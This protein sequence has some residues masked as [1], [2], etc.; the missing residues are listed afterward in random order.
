[1]EVEP[2][3]VRRRELLCEHDRRRAVAAPHVGDGTAGHQRV[4]DTVERVDPVR[5]LGAV[6]GAEEPL[7]AGEEAAVVVA[8]AQPAVPAERIADLR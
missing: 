7:G 2:R 8:P 5:Q 1:V 6:A 3:D 4:G